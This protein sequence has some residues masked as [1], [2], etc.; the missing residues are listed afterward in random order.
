MDFP[1]NTTT[2][3]TGNKYNTTWLDATNCNSSQIV[4]TANYYETSLI[5]GGKNTSQTNVYANGVFTAY[6][7]IPET[8]VSTATGTN[9]YVYL[10]IGL[11]MNV[12]VGFSHVTAILSPSFQA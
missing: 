7:I 11:P 2:N 6:S 5:L 12:D 10:R 3:F 9:K 1:S 8:P 4:L